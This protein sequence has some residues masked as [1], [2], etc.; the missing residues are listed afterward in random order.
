M[1]AP[2]WRRPSSSG[3]TAQ[4]SKMASRHGAAAGSRVMST[5]SEGASV[6]PS[7]RCGAAGTLATMEAHDPRDPARL[8]ERLW[9]P[10]PAAPYSPAQRQ[11]ISELVVAYVERAVAAY[12]RPRVDPEH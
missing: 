8:A 10:G 12:S 2:R 5:G 9:F 11:A 6:S 4:R 7:A 1:S 3:R